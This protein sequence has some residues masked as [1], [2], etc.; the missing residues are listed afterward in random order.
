MGFQFLD[1]FLVK[2]VSIEKYSSE[3]GVSDS[4]KRKL[5]ERKNK[6][7]LQVVLCLFFSI[8]VLY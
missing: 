5:S 4:K 7:K 8:Y 3:P 1:K 2:I 6:D